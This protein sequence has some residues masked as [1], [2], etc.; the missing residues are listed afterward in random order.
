MYST[1]LRAN[2][3][4]CIDNSQKNS[5]D[6]TDAYYSHPKNTERMYLS[7]RKMFLRWQGFFGDLPLIATSV[8]LP[9]G[10]TAEYLSAWEHECLSVDTCGTLPQKCE[11]FT[12]HLTLTRTS[13]ASNM[14]HFY[15]LSTPY[16]ACGRYQAA[17]E[18]NVRIHLFRSA[19]LLVMKPREKVQ[20]QLK[21]QEQTPECSI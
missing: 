10:W 2:I 8:C 18:R 17:K 16:K 7:T 3:H 13:A 15:T 4:P 20:R 12:Y 14:H 1:L 21:T 11:G 9:L 6:S 5:P 19:W